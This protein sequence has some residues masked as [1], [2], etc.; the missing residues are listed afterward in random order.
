[1]TGT[2]KVLFHE[3]LCAL[4]FVLVLGSNYLVFMWVPNERVMGAVQRIFYFH[5]G[6][7]IASYC[8]FA[9]VLVASIIYLWKRSWQADVIS[10][11]AGEVGFV[12]CT[13]VLASGMIWGHSA[14]NTWFSW[15][16]RLVSFLILWLIFLAFNL[17]RIFGDPR[18][19]GV[20][21]AV[22]G[23]LGAVTVPIVILSVR[24]LPQISQLHPRVIEKGG[25]HPLMMRV[26]FVT[27]V[28]MV[29]V[30]F[31]LVWLRARIGFLIHSEQR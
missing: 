29:T 10:E 19:I 9:I 2:K 18:K 21:S 3:L 13:M 30:Q 8:S 12:L 23:I 25:V 6:S 24:F 22:L 31:L 28:A 27:M 15:E 14:W 20:H 17:F 4:A 1:M 16:P 26:V 11:A 5:V 7:A